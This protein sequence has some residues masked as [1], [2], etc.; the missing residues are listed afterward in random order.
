MIDEL[1]GLPAHP[2]LVHA[3][4]VFGPL[5]VG[6]VIGYALVPPVRKWTAWAVAGLAVIAPI[7]LWLAKLSGDAFL[8]R[9]VRAGAGPEFVQ[10]L[11]DHSEFGERTALFGTALGILALVMVFVTTSAARM[12]AN[13]R[14]QVLTYGS[15][16][17]NI[18]L[19]AITGYY[20][21][22][23]GH[24]GASNVWGG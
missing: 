24:T 11:Q 2:L 22:K 4:V 21:F 23:T 10:K 18:V 7:A 12:P 1:L 3:A 5:L 16:I 15:A 14:S 13:T 8:Q 6:L 20:I 19:A 17:L 9:Q